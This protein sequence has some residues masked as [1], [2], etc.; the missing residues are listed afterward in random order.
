MES[1]SVLEVMRTF[2]KD[3]QPESALADFGAQSP[4]VLLKESLDVVDFIVYLEEELG[5][6]IDIR[7]V[8]EAMMSKNFAE[9][10]EEVARRFS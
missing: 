9:I 6:E 3:K 5:C 4:R 2:F 1:T 10:A 8:G 7:E